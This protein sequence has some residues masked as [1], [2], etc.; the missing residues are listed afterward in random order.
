MKIPLISEYFLRRRIRSELRDLLATSEAAW[1]VEHRV[2][3][4]R[5]RSGQEVRISKEALIES[6]SEE[7][8]EW[9]GAFSLDEPTQPNLPKAS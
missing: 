9:E 6:A 3:M 2:W 5:H 4:A 1:A 8:R 7:C